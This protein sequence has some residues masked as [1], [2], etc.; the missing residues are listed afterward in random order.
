M[1]REVGG[2]IGMGNTCKPMAVSFQCMTKSTTKKKKKD[3]CFLFGIRTILIQRRSWELTGGRGRPGSVRWP[4]Q[5]LSLHQSWRLS[6]AVGSTGPHCPQRW[7]VRLCISV[8]FTPPP[9]QAITRGYDVAE[10][11]L[12]WRKLQKMKL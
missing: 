12:N 8:Y 3:L 6:R 2:G 9:L 10:S 5:H 1:E 4:L 7:C 11:S